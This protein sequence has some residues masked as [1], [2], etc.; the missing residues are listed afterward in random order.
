MKEALEGFLHYLRYERNASPATIRD[1]GED[2]ECFR[3][4]V[5]PPG[6]ATMPLREVDHR[7][8]REFVSF[9]YD[10]GLQKATVARRLA[11]LRT[12]FKYCMRERLVNQNPAKLVS[13]PKLPK[14]LPRVLTA[15]EMN[16]FLNQLAYANPQER[17][18]SRGR[19]PGEESKLLLKRD[20]AILELLYASGLRVS[21]LVGLNTGSLDWKGQMLRVLGKGRK[22]RVVPFGTKALGALEAYWPIRREMLQNGEADPEAVFVNHQGGRLTA[23]SVRN[24]VKKYARLANVNWDLHPH[25]LRHAFAT[26]LL[27]DGADLR[28]IQE[29]L[30]H[31]S[32]STTQRYTQASIEQLMDVYDKNHPHA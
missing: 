17:K 15:E 24:I 11:A 19:T 13:T 9:L 18:T 30:G 10:R 22:E 25:S 2:I 23:R 26:H 3:K 7:V 12:F 27:A 32:L 1:Y 29:L 21:E 28:A 16:S 20:R 4:Y 31:V 8:I 5:T 14:R 6:E